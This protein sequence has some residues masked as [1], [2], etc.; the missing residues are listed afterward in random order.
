MKPTQRI[1]ERMAIWVTVLA[2]SSQ[3]I[4][5]HAQTTPGQ[6]QVRAV[7]GTAVYSTP[8]AAAAP[9]KVGTV[10]PSGTTVKTDKGSSVDLFLGNSAGVV[11]LTENTTLALDK[12]TFTDTGADTVVEVQLNLPDGTILGNV[13][14]LSPAS[15]YEIRLPNGVA[16]IRG[17][18][19]RVSSTSFIVL[20]D[21]TLIFVHV[22][23]GG[24]PTPYTLNAPPVV[25]FSPLEGVKPA[26]PDLA[27]EVGN[28]LTAKPGQLTPGG[29]PALLSDLELMRLYGRKALE[30][31]GGESYIEP[32]KGRIDLLYAT[33]KGIDLDTVDLTKVPTEILQEWQKNLQ[34]PDLVKELGDDLPPSFLQDIN[35]ELTKR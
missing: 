8:T 3:A 7:S 30:P 21:G 6:A 23:P 29:A 28:Q 5:L 32:G 18:K 34:D 1:A 31:A 15:K 16:G 11:R 10:L 25:Y 2:A 35:K 26:P 24:Q 17:T 19:Y 33:D 22:P 12:L 4:S 27:N 9:L 14:K 13:N 20:L